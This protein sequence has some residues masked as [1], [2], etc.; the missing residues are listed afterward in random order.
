MVP[1]EVTSLFCPLAYSQVPGHQLSVVNADRT[2]QVRAWPSSLRHA[3]LY[4]CRLFATDTALLRLPAPR[5]F[6]SSAAHSKRT[7][8][9]TSHQHQAACYCVANLPSNSPILHTRY[10]SPCPTVLLY[11]LYDMHTRRSGPQFLSS[12]QELTRSRGFEMPESR[13]KYEI[14]QRGGSS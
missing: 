11:S 9:G 5:L 4:L 2:R 3:E 10:E 1:M 6:S 14:S 8:Y 12:E 7:D 13:V